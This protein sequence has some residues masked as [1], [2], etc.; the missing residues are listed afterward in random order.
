MADEELSPAALLA[1][2]GALPSRVLPWLFIS[3][4][5][6]AADAAAVRA[7]GVG[8]IINCAGEVVENALE[9]AGPAYVTLRLRD[10]PFEDVGA[11]F[12]LVVGAIERARRAGAATL[13]HCHQGVS[14]SATMAIAYVQWAGGGIPHAYAYAVVRARRPI[15]SPNAGFTCQL[16]EWGDFLA[17]ASRAGRRGGGRGNAMV[18]S[19]DHHSG[20]NS[21]LEESTGESAAASVELTEGGA[22]AYSVVPR[23]APLLFQLKRIDAGCVISGNLFK[24]LSA[25]E[26]KPLAAVLT[27]VRS[28]DN[29]SLV[30][31]TRS[32][33]DALC[34]V[35]NAAESIGEG[36][37]DGRP[38]FLVIERWMSS[39]LP[40]ECKTSAATI[41]HC[42]LIV[43]SSDDARA[44]EA[45]T[46]DALTSLGE[47]FVPAPTRVRDVRR[48][49]FSDGGAEVCARVAARRP[50]DGDPIWSTL[51]AEINGGDAD[52]V[53]TA[54]DVAARAMGCTI[55]AEIEWRLDNVLVRGS[56]GANSLWERLEAECAGAHATD[57]SSTN[58]RYSDAPECR[59]RDDAASDVVP[60]NG[61]AKIAA[62]GIDGA[63]RVLSRGAAFSVPQLSLTAVRQPGALGGALGLAARPESRWS[64]SG[65]EGVRDCATMPFSFTVP[66]ADGSRCASRVDSPSGGEHGEAAPP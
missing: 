42:S 57:L 17:G 66:T 22:S 49:L 19:F 1:L 14:R 18:A 48:A 63:S 38:V 51:Y 33:I 60:H 43:D 64:L 10:G 11:L 20:L 26:R 5:A 8:L 65:D 37:K 62:V 31:P 35:S 50:E 46:H 39:D 9:G 55:A 2:H 36:N 23:H 13:V 25:G 45:I 34:A 28:V 53:D 30:R 61:D 4:A 59:L 40:I 15:V 44:I 58:S 3:G 29:R 27:L 6:V 16:V 41:A 12:P 52:Q 56:R 47:L 7:L 24:N 32:T 21:V 54:V